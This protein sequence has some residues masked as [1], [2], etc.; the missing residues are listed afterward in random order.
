MFLLLLTDISCFVLQTKFK[1]FW[2]LW[3]TLHLLAKYDRVGK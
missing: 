2:T 1:S 3:T